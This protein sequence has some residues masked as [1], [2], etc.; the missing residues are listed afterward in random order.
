MLHVCCAPCLIHPFKSLTEQ[1]FRV[2]GFFYNPNIYP[3]DEYSRRLEAVKLFSGDAQVGMTYADYLPAEFDRA[4]GSSIQAPER[5]RKCWGLR[6][7]R[8]AGYARDNGFDAFTST[9]LVSPYQDQ[10]AL[11]AIGESAA[12]EAGVRFHYEDFRPGFRQAHAQ[13]REMGIYCQKYCG[14]SYSR[15]E[16]ESRKKK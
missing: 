12:G 6:M 8:T 7:R 4:I 14:C 10:E 15:L 13:A 2:E 3:S 5:C 11:K 1:G 9:L 16:R